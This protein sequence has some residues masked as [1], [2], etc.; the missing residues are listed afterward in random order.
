MCPSGGWCMLCLLAPLHIPQTHTHCRL[1]L[2]SQW[3]FFIFFLQWTS[4]WSYSSSLQITKRQHWNFDTLKLVISL[5]FAKPSILV[6]LVKY[7]WQFIRL[8]T[9]MRAYTLIYVCIWMFIRQ[10][11]LGALSSQN[12][13]VCFTRPLCFVVCMC[14]PLYLYYCLFASMHAHINV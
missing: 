3:F 6:I 1:H 5:P 8:Y 4:Q 10:H 2:T 14:K 11:H 7:N 13:L 12:N 9:Y